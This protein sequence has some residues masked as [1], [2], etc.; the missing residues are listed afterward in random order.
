L[1]F[2]SEYKYSGRQKNTEEDKNSPQ[3]P[4]ETPMNSDISGLELTQPRV[5]P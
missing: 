4:M 5:A 3:N 1:I 2:I